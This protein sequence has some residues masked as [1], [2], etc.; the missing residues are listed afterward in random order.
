MQVLL[1]TRYTIT[2]FPFPFTYRSYIGIDINPECKQF[3]KEGFRV[4]IGDQG[5]PV[6]WEQF[7]LDFPAELDIFIDDGG[8]TMTQQT[9]AFE[10]MFWRVR[11]G[12]VYLCKDMHTSYWE[13]YEGGYLQ[14]NSMVEKSKT[15]ID[16]INAWHSKEA[17]LQA[18]SKSVMFALKKENK[19]LI[20]NSLSPR[21][22]PGG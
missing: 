2:N 22:Q 15:L 16:T 12:G 8:Y 13:E 14:S 7:K 18:R 1:S 3:E 6:F 19:V 11:E 5:D 20:Y 4:V 21:H 10:S 17:G 9:V